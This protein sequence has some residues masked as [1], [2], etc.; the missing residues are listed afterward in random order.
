MKE[1]ENQIFEVLKE[2]NNMVKNNDARNMESKMKELN[3]LLEDYLENFKQN[4]NGTLYTYISFIQ[5]KIFDNISKKDG[6][7]NEE[8]KY[9]K[10]WQYYS[11]NK[12][13]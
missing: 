2:I 10:N 13:K 4:L 9:N 5:L 11:K 3:N 8:K 1:L 12:K 7:I 6:D